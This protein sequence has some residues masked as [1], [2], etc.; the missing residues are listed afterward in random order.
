MQRMTKGGQDVTKTDV[1]QTRRFWSDLSDKPNLAS[2]EIRIRSL[3]EGDRWTGY[4][5]IDM[6]EVDPAFGN[7]ATK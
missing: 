2:R 5:C 4:G 1:N 6:A 7:I 3:T